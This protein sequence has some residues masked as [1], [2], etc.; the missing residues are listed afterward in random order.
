MSRRFLA[1]SVYYVDDERLTL[2]EAAA[3]QVHLERRP[4]VVISDQN[5]VH[6]TNQAAEWPSILAVPVSSS[7]TYK[8]R[9]D[10][11]LGAGEGNLP[12]KCW[13]RVPAVQM[14]DKTWLLDLLGRISAEKLAEITAQLLNYLGLIEPDPGPED[15]DE[16]PY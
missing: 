2:P 6:G 16:E 14:L 7:T 13:A 9:F 8:T 12:K 3:R 15:D 4:V 5:E 10:V 11:K 1:G